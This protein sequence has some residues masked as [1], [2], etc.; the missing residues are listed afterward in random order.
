MSVCVS[1]CLGLF[2][3]YTGY[4]AAYIPLL[5][6]QCDNEVWKALIA[7]I[8]AGEERDEVIGLVQGF[9]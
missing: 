7:S 3:H 4:E 6:H 9:G 8:S 2:S 1:V 5:I